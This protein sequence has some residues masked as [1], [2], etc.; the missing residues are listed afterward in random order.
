[1]ISVLRRFVNKFNFVIKA[2]DCQKSFPF[3]QIDKPVPFAILCNGLIEGGEEMSLYSCS[4][5]KH[6]DDVSDIQSNSSNCDNSNSS[7]SKCLNQII[8]SL[9]NL[10]NRDLHKLD[11][12]I[13]KI[14]SCHSF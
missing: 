1:M 14:L 9:D 8:R 5:N 2:D 13:D 10:N 6:S 7:S 4:N 3:Y 11:R 12:C